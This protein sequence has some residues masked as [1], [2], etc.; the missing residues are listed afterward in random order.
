MS[1]KKCTCPD[2]DTGSE[3]DFWA[4]WYCQVHGAEIDDEEDALKEARE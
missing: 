1:D 2:P 3:D 4:L